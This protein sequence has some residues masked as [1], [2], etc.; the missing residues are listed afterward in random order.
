[1]TLQIRNLDVFLDKNHVLRDINLEIEDGEFFCLL[2]PS[3]CG[4]S[5]LLKT[6]AG[7]IQESNGEIVNGSK[8]LHCLAP[9][10]RG[11]VIMFQDKRLFGNMNV[12]EN[13]A[14]ALRSKG[15]KKA[16]RVAIAEKFLE[17]VQLPGF[18][19]RR[20]HELSGGQQQ[21][22]ALARA[23]A[24]EPDALLLDEP[25][26][27]LDK[28]LRDAMRL[29]V[30]QIHEETGITTIMVTHD[31]D[32]ALSISNRI[33]VMDAGKVLQVGTPVEVFTHPTCAKV[34]EY[35]S[36]EGTLCGSVVD[37][38]F[39]AGDVS[40][41][42]HGVADGPAIAIVRQDNVEFCEDGDVPFKVEAVNYKGLENSIVLCH[43][44]VTLRVEQPLDAKYEV[45]QVV[46]AKV[47][48]DRV[49]VFSND[50]Q[51]VEDR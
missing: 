47:D 14:F 2:G 10:K 15:V 31:Q 50:A 9:Q 7:L 20:V 48:W 41:D 49:L 11:V 13:V 22:V 4:K 25:F 1:M 28:N 17:L 18:A 38:V 45:G 30:K 44:S 29:L 35:F 21:R 23:L 36:S 5:T 33:A 46:K 16:E 19:N 43:E 12:G 34:A 26:S 32:E 6:I 24:A 51:E 39:T 3:G 40:F 8:K 37:G 42:S 27:A